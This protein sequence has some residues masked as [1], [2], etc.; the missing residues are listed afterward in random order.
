MMRGYDYGPFVGGGT[1]VGDIVMLLLWL[2]LLAGLVVLV[3]WAVRTIATALSGHTP[4][5]PG[6]SPPPDEACSIARNRYA[7]GE[8]TREQYEEICRTLGLP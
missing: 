2:G 5:G 1:F 3:I 8:I 4:G 7:S 6:Q